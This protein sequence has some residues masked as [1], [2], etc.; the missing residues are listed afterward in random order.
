MID[1]RKGP[2]RIMYSTQHIIRCDGGDRPDGTYCTNSISAHGKGEVKR[3]AKGLGWVRVRA[4]IDVSTHVCP[5][6]QAAA[7]GEEVAK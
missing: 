1:S 4:W 3:Q 5:Q 6:C 2:D 7:R